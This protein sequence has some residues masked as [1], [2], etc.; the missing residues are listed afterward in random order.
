MRVA[1]K[2]RNSAP[3]GQLPCGM[4]FKIAEELN[5]APRT[6][7]D[8]ANQLK[9]RIINCQLG[10][11][12]VEKA[13]HE[14]LT[15]TSLAPQLA[16]EVKASL[17]NGKLPC[18]VAFQVARKLNAGRKLVGDTATQLKIKISECQLGCFP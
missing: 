4:A 12:S 2:I 17:V 7:G 9:V 18:K 15:G 14:D 10:F 8:M 5:V 13:T 16:E 3:K 11:F 1:E 6:V